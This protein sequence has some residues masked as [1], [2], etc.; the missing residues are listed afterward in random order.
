MLPILLALTLGQLKVQQDGGTVTPLNYS[1]TTVN[2]VGPNVLCTFSGGKWILSA[3][4]QSQDGGPT[5]PI[6]AQYWTGAADGTL[7]A[8]KNLGALGTGLVKNTSGVP[9]QYA[10]TSCTNQFPRSLNNSGAATCASVSMTADVTGTLPEANGGTG[11]TALTCNSGQALTSDGTTYSC[12]GT[13][14]AGGSSPQVQYNNSGILG[15]MSKVESS[16]GNLSLLPLATHPSAVTDRAQVYA[17][18]MDAGWPAL[19]V[20]LDNMMGT[21]LPMGLIGSGS[22]APPYGNILPSWLAV[23]HLPDSWGTSSFAMN[24]GS[25]TAMAVATAGSF[26]GIGYDAG[27][28]YGSQRWVTGTSATGSNSVVEAREGTKYMNLG[29]GSA[30]RGGF[31]WWSRVS[32]QTVSGAER[33]FFGLATVTTALTAA[34]QPSAYSNTIYFGCDTTDSNLNICS[35]GVGGSATCAS[36]GSSYPCKTA[37]AGYDMWL[38]AAPGGSQVLYYVHRLPAPD[39]SHNDVSIAGKITSSL[40]QAW[41]QLVTHLL[42][43]NAATGVGLRLSIAGTCH[44][45][46]W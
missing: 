36:L 41:E 31:I 19:P 43:N 42:V 14:A 3:A 24:T 1:A 18:L 2:C 20:T 4:T 28:W 8:E 30:H 25:S 7:T 16:A 29:N 6:D 5:A 15:G 34:S 26:Q 12:T 46:N 39:D 40:P 21:P 32:I 17:F 37:G 11:T 38:A 45:D 33:Y 35:N 13:F 27:T 44:W 10:G 9:S 22:Y 23:C